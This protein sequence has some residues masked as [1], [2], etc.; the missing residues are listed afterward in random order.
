MTIADPLDDL[1]PV[2]RPAEFGLLPD[3]ERHWR[4]RLFLATHAMGVPDDLS[5]ATALHDDPVH[6]AESIAIFADISDEAIRA[7]I[8]ERRQI[9]AN[10]SWDRL[11]AESRAA[12]VQSRVTILSGMDRSKG[13]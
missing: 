8:V 13:Q 3:E 12:G 5:W 6:V 2:D 10:E 7:A 1:L 9:E 4:L 11:L